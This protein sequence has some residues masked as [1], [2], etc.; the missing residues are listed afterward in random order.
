MNLMMN[1]EPVEV[2]ARWDSAGAFIPSTMIW[3]GQTYSFTSTGRHWEDEEGWHI[4]CMIEGSQVVE[5]IFQLN[6][7]GWSLRRTASAPTRA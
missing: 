5:L 7:A 3:K 4:L 6:P 1:L 2:I